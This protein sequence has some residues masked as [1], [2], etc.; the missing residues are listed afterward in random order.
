MVRHI[1]EFSESLYD[2]FQNLYEK[3]MRIGYG[4]SIGTYIGFSRIYMGHTWDFSDSLWDTHGT[5]QNL[6]PTYETNMELFRIYAPHMGHTWDF[7]ES[8]PR[9]ILNSYMGHTWNFS[10]SMPHI[11]DIHG[12]FQNL[13]PGRSST[14]LA[15]RAQVIR[16]SQ[17]L[18]SAQTC[19]GL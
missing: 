17:A 1:W 13:C 15:Q 18:P 3:N 8:M 16:Y 9:A 10:E 19:H 2:T 11:W 14:P 7:S 6:C 12:T 5:F 4:T